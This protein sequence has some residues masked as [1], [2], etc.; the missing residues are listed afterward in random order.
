MGIEGQQMGVRKDFLSS[1]VKQRAKD[2]SRSRS[3]LSREGPETAR[4]IEGCEEAAILK[5]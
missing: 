3:N 4:P 5:E 2:I 1:L